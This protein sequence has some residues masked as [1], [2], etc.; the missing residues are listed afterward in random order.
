MSISTCSD[1]L[2]PCRQDPSPESSNDSGALLMEDESEV[3]GNELL[4]FGNNERNYLESRCQQL[5]HPNFPAEISGSPYLSTRPYQD[6]KAAV[7]VGAGMDNLGNTCFLNSVMQCFIHTVPLLQGILLDKHSVQSNCDKTKFCVICALQGLIKLSLTM[8]TGPIAPFCLVNNLSYFSSG[9]KRFQ[10]EDAHE[11]LQCFLDRLESYQD[12]SQSDNI[13]KQVFGGRIVSKLKCCNC[14]H[15][16]DTYEPSIDLSLEIEDADDLLTALQSFTKV[17]KIEDPETKF[18][19]E[20]CK[21]QVSI[22]KQLSFDQSPSVAVFQLKRFQNDGCL[23]QKIDKHVAFP[24]D[25]DLLPFSGK[26]NDGLVAISVGVMGC[27]LSGLIIGIELKYVLYAIVVHVGLTSTSGHYYCFIRLSPNMWCK[28]D[29]S[30]VVL[31]SEDFVLSQEAYILFYAKEGTSW[32]SNFIETQIFS[33]DSDTWNTSP[34][35]VLDRVDT[36]PVF[37]NPENKYCNDICSEHKGV[38]NNN[39]NKDSERMPENFGNT[40]NM[41]RTSTLVAPPCTSL[42][43]DVPPLDVHNE[44]S[45]TLLPK[46]HTPTKL[47]R[48]PSP[49]IYREDTPDA[50]FSIPRGHLKMVDRIACKRRLEKDMDDLETREAC[51]FIKK[52]MP[53]SRGQQM[54]AALRG[55][56]FEVSANRKKSRKS[57]QDDSSIRHVIRPSVVG[58]RK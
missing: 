10:Q 22:E 48:S 36:P 12:S 39:D 47:L 23:V 57:G 11:F 44:V 17:E 55:S 41:H 6:N 24:L 50:G 1:D 52:S 14:G 31:V 9:F 51:S 19:C 5:Q 56:K 58:T 21:E 42:S 15:C 43:P 4:T 26:K 34:K 29:D 2:L 46:V 13:V 8:K 32:F 3:R 53:G 40:D 49:E 16:S 30:R 33:I 27:P 25:L 54:L 45:P 20:K 18:T 28:F 37:S 7:I 35:S 38:D